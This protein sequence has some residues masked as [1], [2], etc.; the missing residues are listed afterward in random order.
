MKNG[1]LK[2]MR[3]NFKSLGT[4]GVGIL[5]FALCVSVFGIENWNGARDTSLIVGLSTNNTVR[6]KVFP[7]SKYEHI[8]LLVLYDDTTSAGFAND[9]AAFKYGYE[10][11][12][13]VFDTG[14]AWDTAW[15]PVVY[16][17]SVV[18][19]EQGTVTANYADSTLT[20]TKN[21]G[22]SDTTQVSGYA[23]TMTQIVPEGGPPLVRV[24]MTGIA[25]N[26]NTPIKAVVQ[27]VQRLGSSNRTR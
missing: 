26:C 20:L 7:L 6:S 10:I 2:K 9:S 19:G 17:D 16:V 27:I 24:V 25:D 14:G 15:C 8:T 23:Y 1:I 21:A 11:G 3:I 22:W 13:P 18:Y 4:P 5:F 12:V